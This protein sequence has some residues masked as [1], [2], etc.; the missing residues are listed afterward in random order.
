MYIILIGLQVAK[1]RNFFSNK[2]TEQINP[3]LF[4]CLNGMENVKKRG[5]K[6]LRRF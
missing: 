5:K 1:D 2:P 6:V 3:N 4:K